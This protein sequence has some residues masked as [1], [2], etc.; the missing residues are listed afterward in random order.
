MTLVVTANNEINA[1]TSSK[2]VEF[3]SFKAVLQAIQT[4]N[5][6]Q[7]DY[8]NKLDYLKRFET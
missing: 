7:V 2:S 1:T 8:D 6:K 5:V 4:M 3:I